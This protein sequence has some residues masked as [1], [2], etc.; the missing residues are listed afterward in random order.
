MDRVFYWKVGL[1]TVI[2][3]LA[4]WLLVPSF[5][6]FRLPAEERNQPEK[7]EAVLPSWAPSAKTRLN[8]GLDIQGGI[9]LVLGVDVDTALKAKVSRRGDQ[10]ASWAK[11]KNV[12]GISASGDGMR[13]RVTAANKADLDRFQKMALDYFQDMHLAGADDNSFYL[14]Y[15]DQYLK[16][17][18]EDAVDQALK[19]ISNRVNRWGVTEPIIAKRGDNAILVQLPGFKDPAKAKE[20]LGKTAQLEFKIVDDDS[21]YFKDIYEKWKASPPEGF[22]PET[23]TDSNGRPHE[24][25]AGRGAKIALEYDHYNGP[26]GAVVASPYLSATT[27][28]GRGVLE[29][30]LKSSELQPPAYREAGFECIQSKTKKNACEG[31][32][33]YLLKCANEPEKPV[34]GAEPSKE[35]M[36][37]LTGDLIVDASARQ[38]Q[39][40]GVGGKPYVALTFDS[41]G[42]Q[43]FA[44]ITGKNVLKRFAI[45]L[46]KTVNSAPVI[47]QRIAGGN[48]SIT[49]GGLRPYQ[50]LISEANDLALVL[51]AGALP[52]PV[53]IGEERT[54]G[55]SLGPE[56]IRKGGYAVALGL[57]L[58]VSFM[59]FYYRTTG[60]VANVALVLNGFLNLAA[61]SALNATLTL[62]GIAAFVLTLGIAVD[63]NVLINERIREELRHGKTMRAAL[64][65]GYG[66]VFWTIFDSHVTTLVAGLVLMQYGSGPVRGFAVMLTIGIV[67]S[68]FTSIVVTRAIMDWLV[69]GRG[70][71]KISV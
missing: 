49:L 61:M 37:A 32:R 24:F 33:T 5:Y 35:C 53:T 20:L 69:I 34:P 13:V 17:I 7:L 40:Q 1:I 62:P 48:A 11:E 29:G 31:Y 52:A 12:E 26:G 3:L 45:V 21:T 70:W 60:A 59:F 30:M 42:A 9:H 43:V 10:I 67:A 38:E 44:D 55:A 56:L 25:L 66:R 23:E 51:K 47:Q 18:K 16:R 14:A 36:P 65:A 19:V 2:A 68:F 46:D 58:V 39:G 22:K 15:Q 57:L 54:V 50:E 8:L 28:N 64:E 41:T 6:Y 27:E 63:A 4:L 71:H